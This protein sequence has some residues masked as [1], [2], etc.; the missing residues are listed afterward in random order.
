MKVLSF[1]LAVDLSG[2]VFMNIIAQTPCWAFPDPFLDGRLALSQ[3]IALALLVSQHWQRFEPQLTLSD[4]FGESREVEE[5]RAQGLL[6]L[7]H[8]YVGAEGAKG[9]LG[10]LTTDIGMGGGLGITR[11]P[12]LDAPLFKVA[13]TRKINSE[14]SVGSQGCTG[15]NGP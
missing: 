6:L 1:P 2:L 7:D 15:R 8:R 12:Q 11:V 9:S 5:L 13:E 14:G 4:V 3:H 10:A